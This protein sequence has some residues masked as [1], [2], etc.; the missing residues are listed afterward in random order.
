M[1]AHV[2][3]DTTRSTWTKEKDD[4]EV[5]TVMGWISIFRLP[6]I[7]TQK[8][9]EGGGEKE[10]EEEE[11]SLSSLYLDRERVPKQHSSKRRSDLRSISAPDNL[12][13]HGISLGFPLIHIRSPCDAALVARCSLC[14][15]GLVR[16]VPSASELSGSPCP[17]HSS[18][19]D[20]HPRISWEGV[21]AAH[22]DVPLPRQGRLVPDRAS[23]P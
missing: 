21:P 19:I 8:K 22:D 6:M 3:P 13:I 5:R 10:E 12:R 9:Q 11:T 1:D 2:V 16:S 4:S 14:R 20:V 18:S 15:A 7:D 23:S 17:I